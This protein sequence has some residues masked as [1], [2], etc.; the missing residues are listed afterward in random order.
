MK[1]VIARTYSNGASVNGI[2]PTVYKYLS[3]AEK[4]CEIL[5][6]QKRIYSN[7]DRWFPIALHEHDSADWD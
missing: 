3:A 2:Y 4:Q 7:E 5:N 1:Y 6:K